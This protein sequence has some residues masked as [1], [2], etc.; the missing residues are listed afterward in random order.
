LTQHGIHVIGCG[1][2][3]DNI[4]KLAAEL[5][6]AGHKGVLHPIKCDLTIES[7]IVAMFDWIASKFGGVDICINNAGI[8]FGEPVIGCNLDNMKQMLDLNVIAVMSCDNKAIASMQARGVDD[9]HIFHI[10]S[11]LGHYVKPMDASHPYGATKYAVTQIN[12]ALRQELLGRGSK[13]RVTAISPSIV[14]TQF[15]SHAYGD[16][17]R[18]KVAKQMPSLQAKDVADTL[19]FAL[20]APETVQIHDIQLRATGAN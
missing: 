5:A 6:S 16:A 20:S 11:M 4:Q 12:E 15:I 8:S 1:R 19:I 18:E 7:D 3:V 9:G 2:S 13:I 17:I 14:D 10:N